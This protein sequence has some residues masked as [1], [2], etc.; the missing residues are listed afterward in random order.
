MRVLQSSGRP[1]VEIASSAQEIID[2]L[3]SVI[4]HSGMPDVV[5]EAMAVCHASP[6]LFYCSLLYCITATALLCI[7]YCTVLYIT[8]HNK[9]FFMIT[10]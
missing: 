2:G 6:V 10:V 8:A 3:I 4:N 1:S 9:I 5:Q 7:L